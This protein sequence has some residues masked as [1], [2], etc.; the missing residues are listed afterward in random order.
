MDTKL[1]KLI[2]EHI[3]NT[4]QVDRHTAMCAAL[5]ACIMVKDVIE[6]LT[7]P[8]MSADLDRAERYFRNPKNRLLHG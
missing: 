2:Y 5:E 4:T 1:K 3:I 6:N 7:P 8:N